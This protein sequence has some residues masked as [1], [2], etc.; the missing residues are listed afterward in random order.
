MQTI[1]IVLEHPTENKF[2]LVKRKIN[3]AKNNYWIIGG[4]MQHGLDVYENM[5]RITQRELNI[6]LNK[7][8]LR[9]LCTMNYIWGVR[10]QPPTSSGTSDIVLTFHYKL[11]PKELQDIRLDDIEYNSS[12][13]LWATKKEM[14]NKNMHEAIK[15]FSTLL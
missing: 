14:P 15:L 9:Y 10:E 13:I 12:D 8:N 7:S 6:S 1:D 2:L 4:R 11:S 3:H 5:S